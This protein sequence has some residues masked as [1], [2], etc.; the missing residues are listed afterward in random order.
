MITSHLLCKERIAELEAEKQ[1][2]AQAWVDERKWL[3]AKV[4]WLKC[5][6]LCDHCHQADTEHDGWR[7]WCEED[8][9]EDVMPFASCH[10]TP[11]RWD[12]RSWAS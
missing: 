1:L 7:F 11:S 4:E 6:T 12:A 10:L 8:G 5:C 9:L 2:E 3:E